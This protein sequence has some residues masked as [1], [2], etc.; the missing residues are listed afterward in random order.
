MLLTKKTGNKLPKKYDYL[1]FFQSNNILTNYR[2][3]VFL[4]TLESKDSHNFKEANQSR[5][6][7]VV[8]KDVDVL[9]FKNL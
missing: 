7:K 8:I 9:L 6:L 4:E 5:F 1:S 3:N 2:V